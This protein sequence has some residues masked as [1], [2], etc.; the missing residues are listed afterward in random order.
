SPALSQVGEAWPVDGRMVGIV[1]DPAGS[2]DGLAELRSAIFA[3]K[4]VPLIIAPHGGMVDGIPVQRTFATARSVEFDAV[5]VAGAPVPA[6]DAL[7]HRDSKSGA[8]GSPGIDPRVTLLVDE[9]FR[10]AK[11]IGA[12]GAGVDVLEAAGYVGAS[13]IV[14]GDEPEAVFA[15]LTSEMKL[16]RA[17]DRFPVAG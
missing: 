8:P 12:W 5:L 9:C 6:P 7:P 2:L 10:H 17:W 15:D 14:T 13:G 4:M 3:A 16:H 1:V 11:A